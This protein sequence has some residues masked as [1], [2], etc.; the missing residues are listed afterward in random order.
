MSLKNGTTNDINGH[1]KQN[2][3]IPTLV[4]VDPHAPGG[5]QPNIHTRWHPD[6]PYVLPLPPH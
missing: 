5:S 2:P 1:G 4:K 3:V 6:I